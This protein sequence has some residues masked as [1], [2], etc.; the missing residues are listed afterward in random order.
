MF[1][2]ALTNKKPEEVIM[3]TNKL[4]SYFSG[5]FGK[6]FF[7]L[8]TFLTTGTLAIAQDGDGGGADINVD[9]NKGGGGA[10]DWYTQWWVWL[11]VVLVFIIIIV[12]I[13]NRGKRTNL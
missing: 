2:V 11:I 9:V 12:A 5:F 3:S 13:T 6:V 8:V 1:K 4:T 10:G 7:S